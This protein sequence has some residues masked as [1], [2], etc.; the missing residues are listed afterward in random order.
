MSE[1]LANHYFQNRKFITAAPL[2]EK[3]LKNSNDDS[4]KKKLIICYADTGRISEAFS[5]FCSLIRTN[6]KIILDTNTADE[7]CPCPD[8]IFQMENSFN[9]N[10]L[11]F[12][13]LLQL[14]MLWLFCDKETSLN[15]FQKALTI[16]SDN[17]EIID[18][19]SIIKKHNQSQMLSH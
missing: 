15:Y 10:D 3:A 8:L 13:I 18:A 7:D 4:L 2:L 14:G 5:L 19:I 16:Q 17:K 12:T 11:N 1:M 6:I 9:S